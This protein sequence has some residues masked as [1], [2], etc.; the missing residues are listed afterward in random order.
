MSVFCGLLLVA[1]SDSPSTNVPGDGGAET[2]E[3]GPGR[4]DVVVLVEE[5]PTDCKA[6]TCDD[7]DADCG[8]V[9]D[10]CG[11]V[12]SCG[13][14]EPGEVCG[15]VER[16]HCGRSTDLCNR[17][18]EG[19]ACAGRECGT[20]GD[21]CGDS[22]DCGSC[23]SGEFCGIVEPFVCSSV[24]DAQKNCPAKIETCAEQGVECGLAG[25]GCGGLLD[26]EAETG[27]CSEGELCGAGGPGRCGAADGCDPI[28]EGEACAG[29]QCGLVS[30]GCG[31]SHDCGACAEGEF[32]GAEVAFE[33]AE[34]AAQ[35]IPQTPDEACADKDCGIVFDGCGGNAENIIDCDEISG[36]C[37]A[38]EFCGLS[39]P[40]RCDS[41][42]DVPCE[43]ATSC[44]E[45]GWECGTAIDECG[46]AFDCGAE[47][48]SC[49]PARETCT[50]G[51]GGPALCLSGVEGADGACPLCEAI[52]NCTGVGGTTEITGRV[53]T[54]GRADDDVA[55]QVG[56]PNAF[57]YIL[58]S[59]DE[60]TL[61]A[62]ESGIP[63]GGL[64]C[65]RCED[66][67]LGPVL[68]SSKSDPL[69]YFSL[70]GD[71][72][73]GEEFV[74]VTKLG[75]W[76]RA[77]K[78]T[79]PDAA[80]CASTE[81]PNA[82]TRLP[83]H[84]ADGLAVNI[85][86]IA[87]T[88]GQI[89]AME[90]VFEKM[91]VTV[92]EFSEP[93]ADGT[94]P[95][96]I[97]LYGE[98]GAELPTGFTPK[99]DLHTDLER[100]MSYDLVV[101]DCEGTGSSDNDAHD[102]I[103]REYVNRGGRVFA[104]HLEFKWIYDNGTL[105]YDPSTAVD[106]GLQ[107]AATWNP[108]ASTDIDNGTGLVSLDRPGANPGKIQDFADWLLNEGAANSEYQL[109]IIEPRDIALTVGTASEEYLYRLLDGAATSVQQFAFNTPYGAPPE[110]ICGRVAYSGFHVSS[111]GDP[112]AFSD[113]VFPEHCDGTTGLSGDLTDQEK[114]L[115]YM[116]FDVGA[117]VGTG[118]PA[119]PECLPVDDCTGRCGSLPDGC[120]G[121]LDC[122]CTDG[123]VC[124]P[125]GL[126]TV[127][128]C[129]VA[130]C[131]EQGAE[132]GVVSDGCGG[133]IECGECELPEVCGG[134]GD[135]NR[136]GLPGCPES[137]DGLD[138]ECGWVENGCSNGIDCGP[139]PEGEY[140]DDNRCIGC[141]PASCETLDAECGLVGDGCGD[142]L[143][144]GECPEGEVCGAQEALRCGPCQKL[145][146]D[147]LEAECGDVGD[148]CGGTLDCGQCPNDEVCGLD[149]PF[150]CASPPE[151]EPLTCEAAEAECGEI[152][153]GCSK[154]VDCGR[155]P[156]GETCGLVQP[157]KCA[158][159]ARAR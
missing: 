107:P 48:R 151:C 152:G 142:V 99:E 3:L 46:N 58:R 158:G 135:P 14:C 12:L 33:C 40:Y 51:L 61:P 110:A 43:A 119:P 68:A 156:T 137:C 53:I 36:G 18:P 143:D 71:I 111:G 17:I 6:L 4:S 66:Q 13:E 87:V 75:K 8:P 122:S 25:D 159:A 78:F 57:V 67:D 83:R 26:C 62:I 1:C 117:C 154:V 73:V 80:R 22:Y 21:G 140:C 134:G 124:A 132:C 41:F 103:I 54:A 30:N 146:C 125:G 27:G 9:S 39:E 82:A 86:R 16:N 149:E 104:S 150:K 23:G 120:G 148:G 31:G 50:G 35:C 155:C 89:D 113:V 93:G 126:C 47:E 92:A 42:P 59:N 65:D 70:K 49:D 145:S 101:F 44:E 85:P 5:D 32:C 114:V 37:G 74:L 115:L 81:L 96:R 56:V 55:N 11:G 20:A 72:P 97:H 100:V 52:P 105:D 29:K 121:V 139:C 94:A 77:Q 128:A 123:E 19:E 60:T 69:G 112:S 106:T 138:A 95:A 34:L 2:D 131:V 129:V 136:C 64:A 24:D 28:D 63:L 116:L 109:D 108:S 7:F 91:G 157:N 90:C 10:G 76:R 147:E 84:M 98:D 127:P 38:G 141:E 133:T 130:G 144:C 79:L 153:D 45:L 15:L 102:P 118:Q 88:T